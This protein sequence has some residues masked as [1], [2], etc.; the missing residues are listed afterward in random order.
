MTPTGHIIEI[1][2]SPGAERIHVYHKS[3]TF[4]EIYP[5]GSMNERIVGDKYEIIH[6]GNNLYV[7]GTCTITVDENAKIY[8]GKDANIQVDGNMNSYVAGKA[9][10]IS[11][12]EISVTAKEDISI[13]SEK[14]IKLSSGGFIDL[15]TNSGSNVRLSDAGKTIYLNTASSSFATKENQLE[16]SDG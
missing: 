1:D 9:A 7:K 6:H 16:S 11:D 14:N 3:G 10:V 4:I 15:S 13:V 2:D 8:V 12:K 5:D